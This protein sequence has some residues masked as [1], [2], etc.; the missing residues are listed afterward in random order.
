[1]NIKEARACVEHLQAVAEHNR[2]E[3]AWR[4]IG[5]MLAEEARLRGLVIDLRDAVDAT[6]KALREALDKAGEVV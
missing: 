5:I 6:A 3:K 1:M 4:A 2:D